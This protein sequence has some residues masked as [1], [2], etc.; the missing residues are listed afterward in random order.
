MVQ[1]AQYYFRALQ[2]CFQYL[3]NVRAL[4]CVFCSKIFLRAGNNPVVLK[5]IAEHAEPLFA[6]L[7]EKN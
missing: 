4:N 2:D 6:A 7:S 5:N 1:C 3:Q